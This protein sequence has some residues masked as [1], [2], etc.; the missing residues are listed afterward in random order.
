MANRQEPRPAFVPHVSPGT[1]SMIELDRRG[2][3]LS[4]VIKAI[5]PKLKDAQI[6][7]VL[8]ELERLVPHPDIG[9]LIFSHEPELSAEEIV[10]R[11][12]SYVPRVLQP[13]DA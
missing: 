4:L 6:S 8:A 5:D 2:R 11:S 1:V 7:Y 3:V 12:L 13:P 10:D 9:A